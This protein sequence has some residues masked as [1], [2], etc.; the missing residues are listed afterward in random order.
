MQ[1]WRACR[2]QIAAGDVNMRAISN[3]ILLLCQ[4][5]NLQ[6]IIL[7]TWLKVVDFNCHLKWKHGNVRWVVYCISCHVYFFHRRWW[8]KCTITASPD[9]SQITVQ[10][11]HCK[12]HLTLWFF[13][14]DLNLLIWVSGIVPPV[15]LFLSKI[16][17][18]M[19]MKDIRAEYFTL[20][21]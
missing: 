17:N 20:Q 4:H 18:V 16:A 21:R 10:H 9:K 11:F 7:Y 3:C 13:K 14:F 1:T 5:I 2:F 12:I 8:T 6:H 19:S 15:T